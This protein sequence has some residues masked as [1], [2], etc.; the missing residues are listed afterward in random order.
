MST[1]SEE[2]NL[3]VKLLV[4]STMDIILD[5]INGG[6]FISQGHYKFGYVTIGLEWLPAGP[7]YAL[8]FLYA[9]LSSS[10]P[11]KRLAIAM[12]IVSLTLTPFV[13]LIAATL[14]ILTKTA[15]TYIYIDHNQARNLAMLCALVEASFEAGLQVVWQ[16]YIINTDQ[17][18]STDSVKIDETF[19]MSKGVNEV[20]LSQATISYISLS[21]SI[22][23]LA[24]TSITCFVQ[25]I[26]QVFAC[27]RYTSL[28]ILIIVSQTFRTLAIILIFSYSM[29]FSIPI[30]LAVWYANFFILNKSRVFENEA[31]TSYVNMFFNS[32]LNVPMICLFNKN[33]KHDHDA[34]SNTEMNELQGDDEFVENGRA[35]VE[36]PEAENTL[37]PE[38]Q[39]VGTKDVE[40][41][42][43][44]STNVILEISLLILLCLI[45]I[46]VMKTNDNFKLT[47][48]GEADF[49]NHVSMVCMQSQT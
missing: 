44:K 25:D 37:R 1:S 46:D 29:G 43:I 38:K 42:M 10:A 9:F 49:F 6:G 7:L 45:N 4:L 14:I 31:G 35:A 11:D 30:F 8:I 15:P 2:V 28:V 22:L 26:L 36:E 21:W 33:L 40:K 18:N 5:M 13:P 41:W 32:L 17:I 48:R 27:S 19:G 34:H 3:F 16:G 24:T 39:E 47:K 20:E 12:A 23:V